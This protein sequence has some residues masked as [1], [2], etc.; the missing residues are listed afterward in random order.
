MLQTRIVA[1]FPDWL[2][3]NKPPS[4]PT[5]APVDNMLETLSQGALLVRCAQRT[6]LC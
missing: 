1:D 6:H 4:V 5:V 2:A 3:V